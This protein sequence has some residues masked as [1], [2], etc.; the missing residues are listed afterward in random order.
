MLFTTWANKKCGVPSLPDSWFHKDI[1]IEHMH[2]PGYH[3][4]GQMIHKDR[5]FMDTE[6]YARLIWLSRD[7]FNSVY[8]FPVVHV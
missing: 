1:D 4:I 3:Y 6:L 7:P 2:V 8:D 5:D